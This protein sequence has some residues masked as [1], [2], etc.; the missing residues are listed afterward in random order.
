VPYPIATGE[1]DE[2]CALSDVERLYAGLAGPKRLV[3]HEG[4]N[5]VLGGVVHEA[6]R[7]CADFLADNL[8]G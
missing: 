7:G 5:H 4:E 8:K 2:L 6:M 1:W 3:V